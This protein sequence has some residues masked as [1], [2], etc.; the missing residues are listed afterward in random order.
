MRH[1][2]SGDLRGGGSATV[3]FVIRA[4][5]GDLR[6]PPRCRLARVPAADGHLRQGVLGPAAGCIGRGAAGGC[7]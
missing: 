5:P 1:A 6:V 4:Q 3:S 2:I 7:A